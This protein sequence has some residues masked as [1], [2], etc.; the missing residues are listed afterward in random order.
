MGL[1]DLTVPTWDE[2]ARDKALRL[3]LCLQNAAM[4][5]QQPGGRSAPA[6][7]ANRG[8]IC[9]GNRRSWSVFA[10]IFS[11]CIGGARCPR[12][13]LPSF[14]SLYT[15]CTQ[16]HTHPHCMSCCCGCMFLLQ[17]HLS[18]KTSDKWWTTL[19]SQDRSRSTELDYFYPRAAVK[20]RAVLRGNWLI[21]YWS[22]VI[23]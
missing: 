1:I 6:V 8:L 17:W 13:I 16:T 15:L 2:H 20:L 10:P 18:V 14:Y 7:F 9:S 4:C 19:T 11:H 21:S 23:L 3:H 22:L 12:Q 5:A